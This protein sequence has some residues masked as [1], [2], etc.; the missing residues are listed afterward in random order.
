[1]APPPY[2]DVR[3]A[4]LNPC[5]IETIPIPIRLANGQSVWPMIMSCYELTQP[6]NHCSNN[7]TTT[8]ASSQSHN[9]AATNSITTTNTSVVSS[10]SSTETS[11][12]TNPPS[13]PMA[14]DHTLTTL[15][16]STSSHQTSKAAVPRQH[17]TGYMDLSFIAVPENIAHRSSPMPLQLDTQPIPIMTDD[18]AGGGGGILDGQWSCLPSYI[19]SSSNTSESMN[20]NNNC[21]L[22]GVN[23]HYC[24]ASA[25]STGAVQL[26]S[27]HFRPPEEDVVSNDVVNHH[28]H[29]KLVDVQFLGCSHSNNKNTINSAVGYTTE[30]PN[31]LCLSL[32]WDTP[33]PHTTCTRENYTSTS[34]P[35]KI[36]STYS[37]GTIAI[38]DVVTV[39][40]NTDSGSSTA[41]NSIMK[42]VQLIERD[43]WLAHTMI[44]S[45]TPAEVWTAAFV[46]NDCNNGGGGRRNVVWS[47]GDDM[48]LKIWDTRS[49]I[50]PM[51]SYHSLLDAG[52][53]CIAPHPKNEHMV[54]VG[55]CM[56]ECC[57]DSCTT[58]DIHLSPL[59]IRSMPSCFS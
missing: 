20:N 35:A 51:M 57:L 19:S 16:T 44:A 25:H 49:T 53:T 33:A 37:N 5:S 15:S 24:F 23:Q 56:F 17:R 43:Q 11:S 26:H 7:N 47:G 12:L 36:V 8:S 58:L 38:H 48:K 59:T 29:T 34:T 27:V 55:S 50:R 9:A 6:N 32:R 42:H 1:M 28:D 30:T 14:S 45:V 2:M 31:P 22:D 10:L 4:P 54:A 21:G 52:I 41:T 40:S 13:P 46:G 18:D 3:T 39:S